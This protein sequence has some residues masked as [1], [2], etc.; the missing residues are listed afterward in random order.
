MISSRRTMLQ[1]AG[2]ASTA[3]LSIIG[4]AK[5]Q[6]PEEANSPSITII[7]KGIN[8]DIRVINTAL[9]EAQA[10]AVLPQKVDRAVCDKVRIPAFEL[11]PL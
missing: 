11:N 6:V 4:S 1:F 3:A 9:L 7:R 5:A 8:K 10:Q 2:V